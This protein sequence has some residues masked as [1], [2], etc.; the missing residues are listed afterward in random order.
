MSSPSSFVEAARRYLAERRALGFDLC[1]AGKRL[2]A[3]ARFADE[4]APAQSLT[5]E[6]AVRWARAARHPSPITGPRRLEIVRPFARWLRQF[7]P[8]TEVPDRWL[9][10]RAHR[11]LAPHIYTC[12]EILA[13]LEEAARL[14]PPGGL[15]AAS[16]RTL[17]GLLASS[18]MRVSE[19]LG[20][21]RADVDLEEAVAVVRRTKFRKSRL[22]PLHP[23]TVRSLRR[24][25]ARRDRGET[26]GGAEAR[27]F[28]IDGGIPLTYSK[29]RT[30]FKRIRIQLGWEHGRGRQPRIHDLRHTFACQRLLQWQEQGIDV[31]RHLLDLSVYL[32]HAKASDTY[33]YLSGFSELLELTARRF[34]SFAGASKKVHP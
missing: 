22:V 11:R 26:R 1:I 33:W 14:S 13:L 29:V 19:A 8:Q 18:G 7:H 3:F 28:V 16:V 12:D 9:L 27:F 20:L 2:L 21:R 15:R 25:V 34:E 5:V 24:Y 32:G 17:L 4:Q 31:N 23:T 6:L 30:A 10:G